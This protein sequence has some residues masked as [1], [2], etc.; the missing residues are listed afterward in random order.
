MMEASDGWSKYN[1]PILWRSVVNLP[2]GEIYIF[3][4]DICCSNLYVGWGLKEI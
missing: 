2:W 4:P 3:I 1:G